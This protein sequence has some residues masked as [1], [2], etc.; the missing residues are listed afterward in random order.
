MAQVGL[1]LTQDAGLV[2]GAVALLH[3]FALFHQKDLVGLS[4]LRRQFQG[5][6][7]AGRAG[8]NDNQVIHGLQKL[9]IKM[10]AVTGDRRDTSVLSAL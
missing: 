8:A 1:Q 3:R 10:V 4:L 7:D 9:L 2:L 6:E 5:G